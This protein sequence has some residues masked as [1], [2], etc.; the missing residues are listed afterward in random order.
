[1]LDFFK[2]KVELVEL[3]ERQL[4]FR[5]NRKFKEGTQTRV[6]V[7]IPPGSSKTTALDIQVS[8]VRSETD[9]VYVYVARLVAVQFNEKIT[10]EQLRASPRRELSVRVISPKLPGFR[11]MTIDISATGLR[12]D[13]DGPLEVGQVIPITLEFDR[14]DLDSLECPA[15]VRWCRMSGVGRTRYMAGFHF[16]PTDEDMEKALHAMGAFFDANSRAGLKE[17]LER[18]ATIGSADLS[19]HPQQKPEAISL[20][21]ANRNE[22]AVEERPTAPPPPEPP[23]LPGGAPHMNP[24]MR[25]AAAAPQ[26]PAAPVPNAEPVPPAAAAAPAAA[27]AAPA[28]ATPHPNPQPALPRPGE[29][30]KYTDIPVHAQLVGYGWEL[31]QETLTIILR[32]DDARDQELQFPDCRRV[33]DQR[34]FDG[35]KAAILRVRL[36]SVLLRQARETWDVGTRKHYQFIATDG[37]VIMELISGPCAAG[38]TR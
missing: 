6:R 22:G 38:A 9:D 13:M 15:E 26:A 20:G 16:L 7:E 3:D 23:P 5:S 8:S 1:M 31:E 21:T 33:S 4:V 25:P 36:D 19:H 37:Q 29:S 32:K 24:A 17:L 28:P 10:G 27:V 12:L 34:C 14:F 11:G 30:E 18:S 35:Q 2:P